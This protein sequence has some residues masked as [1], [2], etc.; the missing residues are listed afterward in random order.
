MQTVCA[1][2]E[3]VP[4]CVL[5]GGVFFIVFSTQ[6]LRVLVCVCF[7]VPGHVAWLGGGFLA[8]VVTRL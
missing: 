3:T 4:G 7:L 6:R 8:R 5:F 2:F 1:A